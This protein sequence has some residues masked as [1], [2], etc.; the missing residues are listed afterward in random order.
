MIKPM[1]V[2]FCSIGVYATLS[3]GC[4]IREHLHIL[5]EAKCLQGCH[6]TFLMS[7]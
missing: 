7:I 2:G 5:R 4:G 1:V 6:K 3:D